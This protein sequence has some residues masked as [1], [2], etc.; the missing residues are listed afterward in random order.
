MGT[1]A[2]TSTLRSLLPALIGIPVVVMVGTQVGIVRPSP[3][4]LLAL[5]LGFIT[6]V[7]LRLGRHQLVW[8][9]L[10]YALWSP[11]LHLALPA[12][13]C[14]SASSRRSPRSSP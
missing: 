10:W 6:G 2:G 4:S 9:M 3:L 14:A 8:I 13:R 7:T 11:I 1:T 5:G 12:S